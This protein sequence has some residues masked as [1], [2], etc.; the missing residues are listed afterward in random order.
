MHGGGINIKEGN[1]Y[2]YVGNKYGYG[3]NKYIYR[4]LKIYR[5]SIYIIGGINIYMGID[6]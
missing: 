4:G 6:I 5:V 2:V 3:G 1:K